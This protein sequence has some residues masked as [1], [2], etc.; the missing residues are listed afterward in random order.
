MIGFQYV[1]ATNLAGA[2]RD[3][4]PTESAFNRAADIVLRDARGSGHNN[5]KIEL[6]RRSIV[7][8]PTQAARGLPQ[9][10]SNKKIA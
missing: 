3:Q 4:S 2:V 6:A 5:F 7:R 9:S 10:Q 8:A 1:R